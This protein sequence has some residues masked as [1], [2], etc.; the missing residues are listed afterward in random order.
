MTRTEGRRVL[1]PQEQQPVSSAAATPP[2]PPES[3]HQSSADD[4]EFE[5]DE[6]QED[7]PVMAGYEYCSKEAIRFLLEEEK[8]SA[9]HP[10]IRQ[11][12]LHLEAGRNNVGVGSPSSSI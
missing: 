7:D 9:D 2:S 12:L 1:E 6:E 11:L 3:E 5:A 10:V 8:L 4:D